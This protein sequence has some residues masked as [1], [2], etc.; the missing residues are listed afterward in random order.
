MFNHTG[1]K[2]TRAL[3]PLIERAPE[4]TP[5][6]SF[7]SSAQDTARHHTTTGSEEQKEISHNPSGCRTI[8]DLSKGFSLA[9]L[10]VAHRDTDWGFRKAYKIPPLIPETTFL[11][12]KETAGGRYFNI[13]FWARARLRERHRL[14][15]DSG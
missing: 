5:G 13:R 3:N 1:P 10:S 4:A 2:R 12:P 14:R 6:N 7:K 11:S 15:Q 8:L 9:Q